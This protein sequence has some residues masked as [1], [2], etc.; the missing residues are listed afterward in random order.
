MDWASLRAVAGLL[1]VIW[2][3]HPCLNDTSDRTI[4]LFKDIKDFEVG[5]HSGY[6]KQ[7]LIYGKIK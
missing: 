2:E 1:P 7:V 5:G 4:K 6:R 3:D